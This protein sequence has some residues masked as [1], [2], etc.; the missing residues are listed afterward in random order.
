MPRARSQAR[1]G[2]HPLRAEIQ[3]L[4]VHGDGS[5]TRSFCHVADLVDGLLY[6]LG[7]DWMWYVDGHDANELRYA[8]KGGRARTRTGLAGCFTYEAPAEVLWSG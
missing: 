5:Q 2:G 1:A 3:L 4:I 7:Q 8:G 6:A